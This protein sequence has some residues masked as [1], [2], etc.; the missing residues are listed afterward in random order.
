MFCLLGDMGEVQEH[1]PGD[2]Q[3]PHFP[4]IPAKTSWNQEQ[5]AQLATTATVSTYHLQPNVGG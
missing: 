3:G 2:S 5:E 4:E 1:S